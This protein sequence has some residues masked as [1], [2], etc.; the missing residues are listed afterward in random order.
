M[1][2]PRIPRATRSIIIE[3]YIDLTTSRLKPELA[4]GMHVSVSHGGE[5]DK[6][7]IDQG[8]EAVWHRRKELG[9]SLAVDQEGATMRML[10]PAEEQHEDHSQEQVG[11]TN[12]IA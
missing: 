1:K 6:A 12:R 7:E 2:A 3:H 4:G 9:Q 5:R 10:E 11:T 8:R